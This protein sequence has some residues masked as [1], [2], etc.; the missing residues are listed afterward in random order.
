MAARAR[1]PF[2]HLDE[3][4]RVA[5]DTRT[6]ARHLNRAEQTMR[7]WACTESGPVRPMRINGRLAWKTAD[8][9]RLLGVK[10]PAR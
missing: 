6:A 9:R 3:E 10:P 1:E 5:V 2:V 7:I 8:I 4:D